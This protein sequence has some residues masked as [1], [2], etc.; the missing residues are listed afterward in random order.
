MNL[1]MKNKAH[2]NFTLKRAVVDALRV[3]V[4]DA[5][6][7]GVTIFGA[8]AFAVPIS[9]FALGL[10]NIDVRSSLGQP[11][12]ATV[13]IHGASEL[14]GDNCFT[15][16]G[17]ANLENAITNA[18]FKLS[19]IVNDEAILSIRTS[20]IINEP[21][22]SMAIM[23]SCD[24]NVRRDYTL[25]LD[26]PTSVETKN[27]ADEES[28]FVAESAIAP[29]VSSQLKQEVTEPQTIKTSQ[30]TGKTLKAKSLKN[31]KTNKSMGLSAGLNTGLNTGLSADL[32]AGL[33]NKSAVT[34]KATAV[35][36]PKAAANTTM[37]YKTNAPRL[38][39]SG[40]DMVLSRSLTSPNLVLDKQLRFSPQSAPQAYAP[41]IAVQDEVTVMNNRLAHMQQQISTLQQRNAALEA[42]GKL[43]AP[44]LEQAQSAGNN[45]PWLNYLAGAGLLTGAYFAVNWWRRRRQT[46]ALDEAE[47]D[48]I[49][50]ERAEKL[51][52]KNRET[53]ENSIANDDFFEAKETP[54]EVGALSDVSEK[55]IT[56]EDFDDDR[57]ILDHA[58][59]FLSHGRTSLAI[60]LLQNHLLDHPKQSV[61]IW[62]FLLDLLAKENMQAAYEQTTLECKE[63]FN[64]RIAEFS[65]DEASDKT[66]FEDFTR[67]HTALQEIWGTP[68]AIVFLD[69]LIYNSRLESRVGFEKTVIEELLLLKNIA[70]E[71]MNTAEVIQIDEKKIMMKERK[72]AQ[73]AAKKAEKLIQMNE[74]AFAD[75]AKEIAENSDAPEQFFEFNLVEYK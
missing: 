51:P 33:N 21:I 10:G 55:M 39:V 20:Q 14:K 45:W 8:I 47:S 46:Q 25:L 42:A 28:T 19:N 50:V 66:T 9:A 32:I 34:D 12:R 58:D 3:S 61:T 29:H 26:P 17:D 64:I 52:Y 15:L 11:L 68:A 16:I 69:D 71:N 7:F 1:Q 72:D 43:S 18:N 38:S 53:S 60:Q 74:L 6:V 4:S 57:N 54:N 67:L 48:W 73:I 24:V 2:S 59:V 30:F 31:K 35:A 36:K 5:A 62:L 75:Q 27:S 44:V 70:N 22:A 63:H 40:G 13:K 23:A 41:E 37:L 65:N 49:T 56:V